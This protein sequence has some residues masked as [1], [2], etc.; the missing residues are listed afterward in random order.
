M[1]VQNGK[2]SARADHRR[3]DRLLVTRHAMNDS[4]PGERDDAHQLITT[5]ADCAALA[6]DVRVI[7]SSMKHLPASTRPRDFAISQEQAERLRGS[8]LTQLLRGLATPG[9]ATLRPVA[10]V[11]L[12]IGLVMAVVGS[13]LPSYAPTATRENGGVDLMQASESPRDGAQPP[14]AGGAPLAPSAPAATSLPAEAA[15][16]HAPADVGPEFVPTSRGDTPGA[17]PFAQATKD[18]TMENLD[19]AY[20]EEAS[21]EPAARADD[22]DNN[23]ALTQTLPT[24][25]TRNLLVYAGLA[26][27]IISLALLVLAWSARRYFADPLLR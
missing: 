11:A 18:P 25:P 26:I 23:P 9:W 24:D 14:H 20:I 10:G 1:T 15:S 21:A 19:S 2:Y 17:Q 6:A 22:E 27:A 4:Y 12:S 7:A 5:C 8:R 3:H 16:T 13:A